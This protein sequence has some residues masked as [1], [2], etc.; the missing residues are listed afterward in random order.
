MKK[1]DDNRLSSKLADTSQLI[2]SDSI[3]TKLKYL[4]TPLFSWCSRAYHCFSKFESDFSNA[5]ILCY[6]LKNYDSIYNQSDSILN[7]ILNKPWLKFNILRFITEK[8][9]VVRLNSAVFSYIWNSYVSSII[10]VTRTVFT[11]SKFAWPPYQRLLYSAICNSQDTY[12]YLIFLLLESSDN[13]INIT[14]QRKWCSNKGWLSDW[15]WPQQYTSNT[16]K[17]W[18]NII[19]F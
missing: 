14:H 7:Q 19:T 10:D 5:Q 9:L 4:I 11:K 6:T 12:L 1:H 18:L 8:F 15:D 17:Y 13:T 2:Y 3:I 16:H